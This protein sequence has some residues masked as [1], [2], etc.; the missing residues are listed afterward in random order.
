MGCL[1]GKVF[2]FI[3]HLLNKGIEFPISFFFWWLVF[4]LILKISPLPPLSLLPPRPSNLL[5]SA[6]HTSF[7]GRKK[8]N[9]KCEREND[10]RQRQRKKKFSFY[11]YI[12]KPTNIPISFL[13]FYFFQFQFT[14]FFFST[15]TNTNKIINF[16]FN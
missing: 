10:R 7:E 3:F 9:K 15:T 16:N 8:K 4:V 6:F 11:I 14:L 2:F 12:Y 1:L 13:F 5:T